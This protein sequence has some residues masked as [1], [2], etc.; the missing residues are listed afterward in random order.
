MIAVRVPKW[1]IGIGGAAYY[2]WLFAVHIGTWLVFC[3]S[4]QRGASR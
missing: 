2:G 3:K 1:G 4:T